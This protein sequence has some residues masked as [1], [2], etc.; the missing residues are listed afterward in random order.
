MFHHILSGLLSVRRGNMILCLAVFVMTVA[1]AAA[2]AQAP[3]VTVETTIENTPG[4]MLPMQDAGAPV[5]TPR[6]WWGP[7]GKP[8][9]FK[10]DEEIMAFMRDANVV[11]IKKIKGTKGEPKKVLLEK[12][13]FRMHAVFRD[14]DKIIRIPGQLQEMRD[15][16]IFECAAYTMGKMLGLNN[17]PPVGLRRIKDLKNREGSIQ[18]WIEHAMMEEDRIKKKIAPFDVLRWKQDKQTMELFDNLIY[19]TD[20]NL[21]NI[22]YDQTFTFWMIDHT[23]A[24]RHYTDL[25]D[26]IEEYL[27][28]VERGVWEKLQTLDD[29]TIKQGLKPHLQGYEIDALL[30]RRWKLVTYIQKLIDTHGEEAVVFTW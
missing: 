25:R 27:T 19:N 26:G 5:E 11:S 22:I 16:G 1:S 12:D 3:V 18:I 28:Q 21:G 14:I 9:P 23:R 4:D 2:W 8:L 6:I 30:K 7:D 15:C 20:R 29:E 10:T 17:I 24:F 13:G